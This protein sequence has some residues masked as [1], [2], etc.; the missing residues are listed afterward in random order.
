MPDADPHSLAELSRAAGQVVFFLPFPAPFLHQV[1]PF[2]RFQGANKNGF[3]GPFPARNNIKAVVVAI[4]KIN[5]GPR[6]RAEHYG[7]SFGFSPGGMTGRIITAEVGLCFHDYSR[8]QTLRRKVNQHCPQ[9]PSG[10]LYCIA[11]E[12]AFIKDLVSHFLHVLSF[13]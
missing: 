10:Y 11:Q 8:G 13:Y 7:V 4:D 1:Q 6:G 5:I 12:K 3:P 9:Q 2:Q